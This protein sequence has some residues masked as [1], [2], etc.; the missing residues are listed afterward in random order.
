M[1]RGRCFFALAPNGDMFPCSE[2][3]GL[4]DFRGGNLFRNDI[5]DVLAT[6]AFLWDGWDKE[7]RTVV[8]WTIA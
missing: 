1:R 3:I 5:D 6:D 2:F 4:K 7:T 8:D